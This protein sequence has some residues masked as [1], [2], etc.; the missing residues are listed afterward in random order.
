MKLQPLLFRRGRASVP[1]L[2]VFCCRVYSLGVYWCIRFIILGKQ[3]AQWWGW[4]RCRF[5]SFGHIR[6]WLVVS[7]GLLYRTSSAAFA[8]IFLLRNNIKWPLVSHCHSFVSYCYTLSKR[9]HA[10]LVHI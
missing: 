5:F 3:L 4:W 8:I 6:N 7:S 9:G 1:I 10:Q 2:S